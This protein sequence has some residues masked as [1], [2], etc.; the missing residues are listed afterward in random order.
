MVS[1][2]LATL[3]Q[4][5]DSVELPL[6]AESSGILLATDLGK[7][8]LI[9]HDNGGTPFPRVQDQWSA[10]KQFNV[11]GIFTGDS[12]YSD[13]TA[14]AELIHSDGNGDPMTLDVPALSELDSDIPVA[15][16]A[17]QARALNLS[18]QAGR[19]DRVEFDL[20]LTRISNTLGEYGRTPQTPTASGTGPITIES[21][22]DTVELIKD[23]Q[24]DRFVGRPNDVVRKIPANYGRWPR[25]EP[26]RKV[27]NDEF[28]FSFA[29]NADAVAQTRQIADVFA[30]S[31]GRSG[32]VLDFRGTYGLGSFNVAPSGTSALR[33]VRESGFNGVTRIP[34]VALKRITI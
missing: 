32:I 10:F 28:E 2:E 20:G 5:G 16:A 6:L 26:K 9:T 29:F 15:P 25:Y 17:E 27:L 11:I 33:T 23:V 4:D 13:A 34:T 22:A 14:L 31:T 24:F 12:A 1:T 3:S 7:P 18:Y 8:N 21:G 19:K 30:R